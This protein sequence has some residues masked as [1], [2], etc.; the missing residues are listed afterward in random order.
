MNTN[1]GILIT[2]YN[3]PKLLRRQID[4]SLSTG[5]RVFVAID[6]PKDNK[7]Q[8]IE[9]DICHK[10]VNE[11]KFKLERILLNERNLG[12][13]TSVTNAISWAFEHLESMIIL[14]DDVIVDE[15]FINYAI[16]GLQY[17]KNIDNI[18][19]LSG[20]N[21]V[22]TEYLSDSTSIARLTC[23][24][25]SWGWATWKDRWIEHLSVSKEFPNW[26][27]NF[28]TRFWTTNKKVVWREFFR[29]TAESEYDAWDFRWQYS[30]LKLQ[31]LSVVPNLNLALNCGFGEFATHTTS[32]EK[33][34]WMP[35]EIMPVENVDFDHV[36]LAQDQIA[37][38][39]M[40]ANHYG[41]T[42]L[43][44]IKI[45]LGNKLPNL[46]KLYRL[47]MRNK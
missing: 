8:E 6:G 12:C 38:N 1:P 21:L 30:N 27:W 24:T 16:A 31:K 3:R 5:L 13:N 22:P 41:V 23:F 45:Q 37:D 29:K 46:K 15:S 40:A 33:P 19:S 18:S 4:F 47:F 44:R 17:F 28:P 26:D 39:W 11:Y 20:M 43:T 14:E 36:V 32:L 10:I 2:G 9:N 34:H 25:S 42:L 7:D 35:T